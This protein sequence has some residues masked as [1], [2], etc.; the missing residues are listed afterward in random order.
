MRL[1]HESAEDG[2]LFSELY[3]IYKDT[4]KELLKNSSAI[5]KSQR[6]KEISKEIPYAHFIE[7]LLFMRARKLNE[8]K[9]AAHMA[10]WKGHPAGAFAF[11][12][13]PNE[14][15][16]NIGQVIKYASEDSLRSLLKL[17]EMTLRSTWTIKDKSLMMACILD[18][19][20]HDRKIMDF[21]RDFQLWTEVAINSDCINTLILLLKIYEDMINSGYKDNNHIIDPLIKAVLWKMKQGLYDIY[22]NYKQ[23]VYLFLQIKKI[24][25]KEY[26]NYLLNLYGTEELYNGIKSTKKPLDKLVFDYASYDNSLIIDDF[27]LLNE[28]T[29]ISGPYSLPFFSY[30]KNVYLYYPQNVS[31]QQP[32]DKSV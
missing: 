13:M 8:A 11:E 6:I 20:V 21:S 26:L 24:V 3:C 10:M 12:L 2:C 27:T 30:N 18:K 31:S 29:F 9:A 25:T 4:E 28:L 14:Y 7:S 15:Y 16:D 32:K 1:M 19:A 22:P 23:F 5:I 17:Q